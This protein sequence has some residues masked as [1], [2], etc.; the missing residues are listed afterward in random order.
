MHVQSD[1][2]RAF[3]RLS[4]DPLRA[5]VDLLEKVAI[6]FFHPNQI[7]TAIIGGPEHDAI[8]CA[9]QLSHR[10]AK[11]V[12]RRGWTIRINQAAGFETDMEQIVGCID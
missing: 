8:A 10:L 1:L 3:Q 9:L 2:A 11:S 7:I 5:P 6:K 12:R 4:K